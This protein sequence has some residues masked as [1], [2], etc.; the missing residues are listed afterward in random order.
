MDGSQKK[1][2]YVSD[3]VRVSQVGDAIFVDCQGFSIVNDLKEQSY[4]V[5]V[6]HWFHGRTVE[7]L[8]VHDNERYNDMMTSDRHITSDVNKLANSWQV[9]GKCR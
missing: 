8:G 2:P 4:E 6:S 1:L 3:E 9:E 5:D 7:L